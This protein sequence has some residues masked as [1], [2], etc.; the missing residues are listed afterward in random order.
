MT[1]DLVNA[2]IQN[3]ERTGFKARYL[4]MTSSAFYH[5]MQEA[6]GNEGSKLV[7]SVGDEPITYRDLE[8]VVT[9]MFEGEPVKVGGHVPDMMALFDMKPK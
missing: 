6:T 4:V 9:N 2:H 1:T 5:L 3:F 7:M 8:V